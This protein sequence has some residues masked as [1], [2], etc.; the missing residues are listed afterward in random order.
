MKTIRKIAQHPI[1]VFLLITNFLFVSCTQSD[2]PTIE[3]SQIDG[4]ELFKSIIF[5]DG[6]L[7]SKIPALENLSQT[8]NLNKEELKQF[9]IM[10]N[11]FIQYISAK[12]INYFEKFKKSISSKNPEIISKALK[13]V[14]K[15]LIPWVNSKLA[16]K[17]LTLEKIKSEL[18]LKNIDLNNPTHNSAM[19]EMCGAGLVLVFVVALV[20]VGVVVV[21]LAYWGVQDEETLDTGKN[22]STLDAVSIQIAE[23]AAFK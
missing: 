6:A 18:K 1:F 20:A 22:S 12:D 8:K 5:T 10:Q 21:A 16:L 14:S 13:S 15:D 7:T 3:T 2:S 11:E 19:K 23:N 4:I 9:R 17:G